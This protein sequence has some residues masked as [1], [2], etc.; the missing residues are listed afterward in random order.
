MYRQDVGQMVVGDDL[1]P[2]PPLSR[3]FVGVWI[4]S[5]RVVVHRLEEKRNLP[6]TITLFVHRFHVLRHRGGALSADPRPSVSFS[7]GATAGAAAVHTACADVSWKLVPYWGR[8]K[9]GFS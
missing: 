8:H 2:F 9:Q 6:Q 7:H 3:W 5:G 1:T 4:A